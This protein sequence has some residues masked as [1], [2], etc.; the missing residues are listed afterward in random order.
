VEG[1][2]KLS[3]EKENIALLTIHEKLVTWGILGKR[4][5]ILHFSKQQRKFMT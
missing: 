4:R 2:M 3:L 5:C 1:F